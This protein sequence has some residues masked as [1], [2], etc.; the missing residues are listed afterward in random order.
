MK[1]SLVLVTSLF[2][3]ATAHA[4]DDA[5]LPDISG[6]CA[7]DVADARG[8]RI[9]IDGVNA[10]WFHP[11]VARCMVSRLEA[12]PLYASRV[13]LLEQRLSIANDR[14]AL[15]AR[16]V[17]LAEQGEQEAVDVLEAAQRGQREAEESAE[18]ERSLRWVWFGVGVVAVV[19]VEALAIWVFSQI[20]P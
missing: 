3:S 10:R 14:H 4:Q 11:D 6:I 12:L 20:S 19:V 5:P 2:L 7:P 13:R 1:L 9:D 8:G 15:M 18:F 16:Q 17:Q